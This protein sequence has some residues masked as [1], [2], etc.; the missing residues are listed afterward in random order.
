MLLETD[1]MSML[2]TPHNIYHLAKLW[3]EVKDAYSDSQTR[4]LLFD[5]RVYSTEYQ[6]LALALSL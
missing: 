3:D 4:D 2:P 1:H 6:S 5:K